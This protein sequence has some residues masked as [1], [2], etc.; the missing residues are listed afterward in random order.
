MVTS[1]GTPATS[2]P[3]GVPARIDA[4]AG[5]APS[6][7]PPAAAAPDAKTAGGK[8]ADAAAVPEAKAA[9]AKPAEGAA[10]DA[11]APAADPRP[12][13]TIEGPDTAKVG[14]EIS[15]SVKLASTSP[16]GR[17]RT[18]VGFDAAALQL[19]SAEP[20]DL[21][22]SGEAPKVDVKPGGV[23]LELGGGEGTPVSGGG[24]LVNL[25][26]RVVAAR[27]SIAVATQIVL[28][29]QDGVAVA[30][31]QATPLKIAVAP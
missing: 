13:V 21:A 9:A 27:P 24:S 22:P 19:V 12:K 4:A 31:T 16:V 5:R 28:I 8:P 6:P 11:P 26:F 17:I 15:V 1:P 20:G 10:V 2:G 3:R 7:P 18:Q 23:Q 14:D 30:A 29:G 25:R